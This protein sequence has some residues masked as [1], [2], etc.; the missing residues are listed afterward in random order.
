MHT[1]T[2]CTFVHTR[3][4]VAVYLRFFTVKRLNTSKRETAHLPL[5]SF[6]K[7]L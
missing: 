6:R 2:L 1:H 4:F 7:T 3:T 5:I